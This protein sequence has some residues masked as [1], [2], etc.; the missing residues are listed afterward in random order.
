MAIEIIS[1]LT[2]LLFVVAYILYKTRNNQEKEDNG[3][4]YQDFELCN[5]ECYQ[6]KISQKCWELLNHM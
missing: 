2:F 6:C 3:I 4:P 5:N 1:F